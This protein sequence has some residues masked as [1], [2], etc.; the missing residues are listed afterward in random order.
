[1]GPTNPA[2]LAVLHF[3]RS[4]FI[5]QSANFQHIAVPN[6]CLKLSSAHP[7]TFDEYNDIFITLQLIKS[8]LHPSKKA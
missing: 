4:S 5:I 7:N 8:A 3:T 6:T 2:L 1:M